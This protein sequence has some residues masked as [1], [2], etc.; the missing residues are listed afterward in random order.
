MLF[1]ISLDNPFPVSSMEN[2]MY[3]FLFSIS[4]LLEYCFLFSSVF[5]LFS[6]FKLSSFMFFTM[7]EIAPSSINLT[8][9]E[10]RLIS[11]CFNLIWSVFITLISESIFNIKFSIFRLRFCLFLLIKVLTISSISF[12]NG[13]TLNSKK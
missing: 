7:M 10:S 4:P 3:S 2:L 5:N 6:L 1:I 12:K 9:F 13:L 11:I 8:A